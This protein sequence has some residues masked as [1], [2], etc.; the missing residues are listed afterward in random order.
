MLWNSKW[1]LTYL[2]PWG[3]VYFPK[4]RSSRM[5]RKNPGKVFHLEL[6]PSH[7]SKEKHYYGQIYCRN[8][9][10][11]TDKH[12]CLSACLRWLRFSSVAQ[13]CPTPWL[14]TSI[15]MCLV[16]FSKGNM[17]WSSINSSFTPVYVFCW[18]LVKIFIRMNILWEKLSR[19]KVIVIISFKGSIMKVFYSVIYDVLFCLQCDVNEWA[20]WK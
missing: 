20:H 11:N 7:S 8:N 6:F 18:F 1:N 9:W 13:S 15:L 3:C 12:F 5:S 19:R 14:R 10:L 16:N 17:D 4:W 2:L